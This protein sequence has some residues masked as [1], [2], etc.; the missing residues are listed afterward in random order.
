MDTLEPLDA[1][2]MDGTS[3]VSLG[4]SYDGNNNTDDDSCYQFK[5]AES[6]WVNYSIGTSMV[7]FVKVLSGAHN[8]IYYDVKVCD[9]RACTLCGTLK[10]SGEFETVQCRGDELVSGTFGT[11]VKIDVRSSINQNTP[12]KLCE[13]VIFGKSEFNFFHAKDINSLERM[14]SEFRIKNCS[15]VVY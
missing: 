15:N 1:E 13:V 9:G 10:A 3:D 5:E 11:S 2:T 4:L 8:D 6:H 12:I 14:Y 7:N